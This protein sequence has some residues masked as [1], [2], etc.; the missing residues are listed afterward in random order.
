MEM[1]GATS[2]SRKEDGS[3]ITDADLRSNDILVEGLS[4]IFPGIPIISE[5]KL[6][7]TLSRPETFIVIDPLDGTKSYIRGHKSF[8]INLLLI[9]Q[10]KILLACIFIPAVDVACLYTP[11]TGTFFYHL[12]NVAPWD[13]HERIRLPALDIPPGDYITLIASKDHLSPLTR[14]FI[15]E[16]TREVPAIKVL[17]V[18]SAVKFCLLVAG[19]AHIYP[20][21]GTTTNLWDMGA[22]IALIKGAGG[23]VILTEPSLYNHDL[24]IPPFLLFSP[25]LPAP[26][27]ELALTIFRQL[28]GTAIEWQ[29]P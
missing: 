15:E 8:C 3:P 12:S 26:V 18:G 4:A 5:E 19:Y 25:S 21:P 10:R 16:L 6:P 29:L 9:H 7:I 27:Q 17:N 23:R 22:G 24:K 11:E 14:Q 20:R 28:C 1:Q 13:I 2:V